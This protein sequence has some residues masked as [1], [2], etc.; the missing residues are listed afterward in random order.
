MEADLQNLK[1]YEEANNN[2]SANNEELTA[3]NTELKNM[4]E[5]SS[6]TSWRKKNNKNL[7]VREWKTLRKLINILRTVTLT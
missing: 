1:E 4:L 2:L 5:N 3:I 7:C 6:K